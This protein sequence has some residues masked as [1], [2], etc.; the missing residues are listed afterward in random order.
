MKN[1]HQLFKGYLILASTGIFLLTSAASASL[2][3]TAG[4]YGALGGSGVQNVLGSYT[5]VIGDLGVWPGNSI[6]N[7]SSVDGGTG[8]FTGT[9]HRTDAQ[10]AQA[11]ADLIAA[12]NTLSVL[13]GINL[14][15]QDLGGMTL[16]PGVYVF[17]SS[18]G[19]T[20]T[21]TLDALN[22]P[23]ARFVFITGS[24]LTT[25]SSSAINIININTTEEEGPNSGV[26]WVIGSS[27]T[28]GTFSSFAGN[29]LA[30]ISITMTTGT[31][32]A[33]GRTLAIDGAV[34]LDGATLDAGD[35]NGGF[36]LHTLGLQL[37]FDLVNDVMLDMST[38][39]GPVSG[40]SVL[41]ESTASEMISF[42]HGTDD[43]ISN[44]NV[45][46]T[47]PSGSGLSS[48]SATGRS[49]DYG[50][51]QYSYYIDGLPPFLANDSIYSVDYNDTVFSSMIRNAPKEDN[52][53]LLGA[54]MTLND[55]IIQELSWTYYKANGTTTTTITSETVTIGV[56]IQE[57]DGTIIYE[58]YDLPAATASLDLSEEGISVDYISSIN[59]I[60]D[61]NGTASGLHNICVSRYNVSVNDQANIFEPLNHIG[62]NF[63]ISPTS[64]IPE[65]FGWI[66]D[67]Y[68][69]WVYS[70]SQDILTNGSYQ[71]DGSGWMYIYK[72][73]NLQ[74]GFYFYRYAT[75]SWAWTNYNW[76]GWIYDYGQD[77]VGDEWLDITP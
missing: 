37:T 23:N 75:D 58:N 69:P 70:A 64:L 72:G 24:T 20:G 13:P 42:T 22:D 11:H 59:L 2:L 54:S 38:I 45:T 51:G 55:S 52:I 36:G 41:P 25:A 31:T 26:Y 73:G 76:S 12:F 67:M 3:G 33:H 17:N 61:A 74:D 47:G 57:A 65:S 63:W 18:A 15:D 50:S 48:T 46:F 30:G 56:Q 71:S 66:S 32:I 53:V 44:S 29:I 77:G 1:H 5:V 62:E 9:L 14:T 28:L 35:A 19:L 40:L 21:L 10:A 16:Y 7:F 27:A 4:A 60:Y 8:M 68:F 49:V 34:T 43:T 6:T 39:N